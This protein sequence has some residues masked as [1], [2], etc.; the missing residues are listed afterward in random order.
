MNSKRLSTATGRPNAPNA[1]ASVSPPNSRCLRSL[2]SL[3]PA[4]RQTW[5]HAEPAAIRAD[6]VRVR[7]PVWI[8]SALKYL[9]ENQTLTW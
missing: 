8:K 9:L 4:H 6:P 5:E 7:C 3:V 1:A 2:R